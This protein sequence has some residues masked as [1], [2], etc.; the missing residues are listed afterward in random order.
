MLEITAMRTS[1]MLTLET[2]VKHQRVLNVSEPLKFTKELA[3][4]SS[5][6]GIQST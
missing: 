4:I 1:Q 5:F 6:H 2:G 3:D